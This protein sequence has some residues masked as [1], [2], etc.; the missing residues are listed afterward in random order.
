MISYF[1]HA[2]S[3]EDIANVANYVTCQ[4][5]AKLSAVMAWA[6]ALS[7]SQRASLPHAMTAERNREASSELPPAPS[8][9]VR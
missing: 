3:N 9:E 1:G 2:P 7:S 8:E 6:A 4:F 5:G